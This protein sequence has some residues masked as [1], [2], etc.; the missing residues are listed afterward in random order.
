MPV[1][2]AELIAELTIETSPEGKQSPQE[3]FD[4]VREA[5]GVTGLAR[6][7]GPESMALAG[8]KAEVLEALPG[9]IKAALDAGA[10]AVDVRVEVPSEVRQET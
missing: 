3:Q 9:V 7:S 8:G 4:A 6:E 10:K 2:P 5:A 1:P